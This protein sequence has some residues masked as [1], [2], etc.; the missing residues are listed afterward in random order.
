MK[1]VKKPVFFMVIAV[2]ALFT[3]TTAFGVHYQYGDIVKTFVHGVD[4]IRL[5]IDIQ[6]GVDVTFEPAD[7]VSATENQMDA[8]LETIKLRLAN[9]T[10]RA[11]ESLFGSRG[12]PARQTSIRKP[13]SRN[14][15]R[16]LS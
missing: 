4:D 1:K 10:T 5:G 11:T 2:I 6:G 3:L 14:W 8:A 7:G 13:Q 12:R 9:Q 15:G 16:P